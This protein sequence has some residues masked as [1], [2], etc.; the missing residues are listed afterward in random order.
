MS[1]MTGLTLDKLR[2][3]RLVGAL[4]CCSEGRRLLEDARMAGLDL[5]NPRPGASSIALSATALFL[6]QDIYALCQQAEPDISAEKAFSR[7]AM[8]GNQLL[9]TARRAIWNE[10]VS[11][12]NLKLQTLQAQETA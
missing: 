11:N 4:Y 6:S 12:S 5:G 2:T 8:I 10:P 3:A 1:P 9:L 7:T